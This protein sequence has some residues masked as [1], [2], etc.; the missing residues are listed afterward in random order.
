MLSAEGADW[1]VMVTVSPDDDWPDSLS[2]RAEEIEDADPNLKWA[3][4]EREQAAFFRF[5]DLG[6]YAE[7]TVIQSEGDVFPGDFHHPEQPVSFMIPSIM[8]NRS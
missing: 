6:L 5:L 3:G 4:I 2:L 7:D 1:S 8:K